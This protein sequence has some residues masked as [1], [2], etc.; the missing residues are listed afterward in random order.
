MLN[1]GLR[2]SPYSPCKLSQSESVLLYD[3]WFTANQFVLAPSPLRLAARTFFSELNTCGFS[4]YTRITFSPTRGW[5]CHICTIAAGPSQ[6]NHSR[7]RLPWDSRPYFTVS[8]SRLPFFFASYDSQGYGGG[9]QPRLHTGNCESE[10]S[11]ILR[12]TVS[13]PVCLGIKHPSGACDQIFI[14]VRRLQVC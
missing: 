1:S 12:P 14:T 2:N 7:V 11:C 13:Q 10:S 6:R 5:V 9:I 8:D 3:W 4:P